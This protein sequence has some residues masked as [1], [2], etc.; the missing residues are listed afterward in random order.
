MV[1][2]LA[3]APSLQKYKHNVGLKERIKNYQGVKLGYGLHV[4]WAIEGPIGTPSF[5]PDVQFWL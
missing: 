5:G 1:A 2:E 3:R 4:G